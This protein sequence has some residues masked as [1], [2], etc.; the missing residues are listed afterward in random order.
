MTRPLQSALS[1]SFALVAVGLVAPVAGGC[2]SVVPDPG[3]GGSSATSTSTGG[4]TCALEAPGKAF[5]FHVFNSSKQKLTLAF[6]CGATIPLSLDTASGTLRAGPGVGN[7]TQC[8]YTCEQVY[9][10]GSM[11]PCSDCGAGVGVD[12]PPGGAANIPWDRRVYVDFSPEPKC[13]A[14]EV[15]GCAKGSLVA[16]TAMQKGVLTVC[17]D[18]QGTPLAGDCSAAG[19]LPVNFVVD[20]TGVEATITYP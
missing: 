7:G 2:G 1:L 10:G 4:D 11:S 20:T 5:T 16:P 17:S 13:V 19:T 3:S 18:A 14:G 8:E 12:L 6:G 9:K 15:A